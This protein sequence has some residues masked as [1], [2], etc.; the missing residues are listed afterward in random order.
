MPEQLT[1][2]AAGAVVGV[3]LYLA[4]YCLVLLIGC[5]FEEEDCD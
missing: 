2:W 1:I 4:G 3:C 5:L